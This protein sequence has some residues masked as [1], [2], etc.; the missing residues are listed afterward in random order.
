MKLC[1]SPVSRK[2]MPPGGYFHVH[3]TRKTFITRCIR[4]GVPVHLT[5]ELAGIESLEVVK[6]HYLEV[7]REDLRGALARLP[8]LF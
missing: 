5:A 4:N 6:A 8:S 1:A 2:R 3:A 7:G